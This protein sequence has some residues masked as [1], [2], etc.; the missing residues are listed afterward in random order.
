VVN[1]DDRKKESRFQ[2]VENEEGHFLSAILQTGVVL[3]VPHD[4]NSHFYEIKVRLD[5]KFSDM[6]WERF[7]DGKTLG[8]PSSGIMGKHYLRKILKAGDVRIQLPTFSGY[9]LVAQFSLAGL[10]REMLGRS[11]GLE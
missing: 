8:L 1:S 9:L 5:N 7:E 3:A 11:C 6:F 2:G 4:A 10:N